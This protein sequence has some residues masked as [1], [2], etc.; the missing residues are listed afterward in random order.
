MQRAARSAD[1]LSQ[2]QGDCSL[3]ANQKRV[4]DGFAGEH[5]AEIVA[6]MIEDCFRTALLSRG[7][8]PGAAGGR[9]AEGRCENRQAQ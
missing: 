6:C 1:P 2:L 4:C 7:D 8:L 3:V 9:Q 5:V